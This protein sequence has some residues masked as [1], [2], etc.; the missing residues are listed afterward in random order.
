MTLVRIFSAALDQDPETK[1]II[2]RGVVDQA[3][4]KYINMA[5]YQR[6]QGFSPRHIDEIIAGY[7]WRPKNIADITIGMRGDR[8]Q[9]ENGICFLQD[10]CYC[11]D[12]GQRL[13]AAAMA[14]KERPELKISL[15]AKIYLNTTEEQ[16][17]EMFCKLG[18]TQKRIAPSVLMRN[19]KKKSSAASILVALNKEE[20]FAL[21]DRIAWNQIKTR[22]ELISGYTFARVTAALHA[23]KGGAL[24]STQI[25][26]LLAGLD[27]L[28]ETIGEEHFRTNIIRLFDAIDACWTIRNLSG[29]RD[30]SR[31][32]L[33]PEFL[34]TIVRLFSLYPEFWDGTE[35]SEFYFGDKYLKRLQ[36]FKLSDYLRSSVVVPKDVLFEV[37]RKRLNLD[38]MFECVDQAAE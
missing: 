13:Y 30:E 37:L 6:E 19:R 16:E 32:H 9:D 14:L 28:V 7:F 3:S 24:K 36:R 4:F 33:K 5:W 26:D 34:L 1:E 20:T 27:A 25:Y 11:I 31:P 18:T 21:K 8:W 10:K 38:P 22:H 35:R 15:G 17:N 29:G 2:I 12:G 23:H